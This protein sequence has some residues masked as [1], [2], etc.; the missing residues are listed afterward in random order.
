[1]SASAGHDADAAADCDCACVVRRWTV[2]ADAR[3]S[4]RLEAAAADGEPV[5]VNVVVAVVTAADA[6]IQSRCGT[7]V[8]H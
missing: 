6:R 3:P 7:D 2:D 8:D 5:V 4:G 1:M